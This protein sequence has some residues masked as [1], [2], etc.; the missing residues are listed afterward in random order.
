MNPSV[1]VVC[2]QCLRSVE[3]SADTERA[4]ASLCPH[5]GGRLDS[6]SDQLADSSRTDPSG[7]AGGTSTDLPSSGPPELAETRD[8][9]KTWTQGS[10]GSLGRFQLREHLGDGGFGEVFRAYDPR[11]DRDVAVK[12]LKQANPTERVMERFFREAR[13]VARLD[14]PNIVAVLDSGFDDGRCWVAYQLVGGHPLW[15]YSDH[16]RMDAA[17]VARMIR[18]LADA[19]DHSHGMGVVHRDIKPANVLIDDQGRPRLI[20]FGLARRSDFA[21]DLTREGAIVGTPA[22]MS[23]EQ[24]L[25]RSR[26]VDERSDVYSLG[27]I[28]YELLHGRRPD[29]TGRSS[30]VGHPGRPAA[31]SIPAELARICTKAMAVIPASRHATARALADD[32]DGWLRVQKAPRTRRLLPCVHIRLGI[33]ALALIL[34][35]IGSLIAWSPWKTRP[36]APDAGAPG[37]PSA[38]GT[39]LADS[40][41]PPFPPAEAGRREKIAS[42]DPTGRPLTDE[43][44]LIGNRESHKYH[45]ETCHLAKMMDARHRLPIKS[46]EQAQKDGYSPCAVCLGTGPKPTSP[47]SATQLIKGS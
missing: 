36:D 23:P 37:R 5:C 3:V 42:R 24:A 40:A 9:V 8:W 1:R 31:S 7:V 44:R 45:L 2:G 4:A 34:I 17:T 16:H 11:L 15:W 14:H 21:S 47:P 25:G 26:Q 27:V 32:L 39:L 12:V 29:E 6:D 22:Y 10:L 19:L 43:V 18:A 33:A 35:V 20:D 13:A 46:H 41:S 28:F 30:I 38:T